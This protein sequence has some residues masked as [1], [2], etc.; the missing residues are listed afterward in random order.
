MEDQCPQHCR[1]DREGLRHMI[2]EIKQDRKERW[3][4]LNSNRTWFIVVLIG[5]LGGAFLLLYNAINANST[6]INEIHKRITKEIGTLNEGLTRELNRLNL[7][8]T[9]IDE[10]AKKVEDRHRNSNTNH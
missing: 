9:R 8:V 4:K 5:V 2:D 3:N 10:R 6:Q 1:E 7:T